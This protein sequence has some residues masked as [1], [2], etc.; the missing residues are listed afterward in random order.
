MGRNTVVA[1]NLAAEGKTFAE[2]GQ[3]AAVAG[4]V[5]VVAVVAVSTDRIE[6]MAVVLRRCFLR[7]RR[8]YCVDSRGAQDLR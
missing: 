4:G 8:D 3:S 5:E 2:E 1:E 6:N 7:R